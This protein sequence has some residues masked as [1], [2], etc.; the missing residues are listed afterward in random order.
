MNNE[1][2]KKLAA[3][4]FDH[5]SIPG[6][7]IT[8]G[9]ASGGERINAAAML[10][11]LAGKDRN[12]LVEALLSGMIKKPNGALSET[13]AKRIYDAGFH[14]GLRKAENGQHGSGTFRNVDGTPSWNE[15][16]L[17]CQRRSEQLR[18]NERQFIDDM[19][20]RTVWREPTER[21][22]MWLMSIFY[23]LGGPK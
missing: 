14:D 3:V 17:W 2:I 18:E 20:S 23:R 1:K 4:L 12:Q 6:E 19:A 13:D 5:D 15:I 10:A 22:G 21:Q 7:G 16:A 9:G 11:R 8:A